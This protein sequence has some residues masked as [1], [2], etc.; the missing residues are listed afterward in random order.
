MEDGGLIKAEKSICGDV[1]EM[2]RVCIL[3]VSLHQG[4]SQ[5]KFISSGH[6][7]D[8]VISRERKDDAELCW[9]QSME[10]G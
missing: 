9:T 8:N 7:L 6:M 3:C 4:F 5:L 2:G 10:I 1:S